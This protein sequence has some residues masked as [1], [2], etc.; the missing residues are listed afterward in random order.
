MY[1]FDLCI[2]GKKFRIFLK[3]LWPVIVY[4]LKNYRVETMYLSSAIIFLKYDSILFLKVREV[5]GE[6]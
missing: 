4:R 1:S 5:E 2:H 6:K 3:V